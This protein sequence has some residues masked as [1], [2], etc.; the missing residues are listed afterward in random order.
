MNMT[1]EHTRTL[2]SAALHASGANLAMAE[3]TA[4]A[5]VLAEA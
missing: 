2:V 3:S 1:M 4:R 5:L